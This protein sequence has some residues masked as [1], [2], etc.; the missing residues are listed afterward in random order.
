MAFKDYVT[1]LRVDK[2][3][4]AIIWI[5]QAGFILKTHSGQLIAIDPYL[6][7][8]AHDN[9]KD[10]FGFGF[11]R[12][13]PA[14]F[15]AKDICFDTILISHEHPDHLDLVSLPG[16]LNNN[17]TTVYM[18]KQSI[19]MSE[20]VVDISRL[21]LAEREKQYHVNDFALTC[22][23]ADHGEAAPDALG[24][25]LDFGFAK[26]YFSGDTGYNKRALKAVCRQQPEICI[27]PING[28]FGNLNPEQ[29]FSL[30]CEL[31]SRI[32]IPCHYWMLPMHNGD[33]QH[34]L[35]CFNNQTKCKPL[36]LR[37]GEAF[38]YKD[39]YSHK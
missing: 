8:L 5:G 13:M 23:M 25:L 38:I 35:N 19:Q 31:N 26:I 29:A 11:K 4:I 7:D 12:I 20:T 1:S 16:F 39:S 33:P 18:N 2:Q 14:L 10:A 22:T 34:F 37:L 28:A 24:F 21:F 15:D 36:L 32:C 30:A 3:R 6:S 17:T 27:L 9:L